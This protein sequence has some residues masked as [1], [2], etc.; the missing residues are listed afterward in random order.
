M[1]ELTFITGNQSKADYLARYLGYPIQHHKLDLDE[2][3]SLELREIVEHKVR[4]AYAVIQRPVIVEDV[5][6]EF[7]ALGRLP[8]TF[9]KFFVDEIPFETI[10]RMIDGMSRDATAKCVFGYFDGNSLEFFEGMLSGTIAEHPSGKNGF[11]WDKIFIPEG[12]S[13][14]RA[15]LDE[16]NDKKTY[17]QIKPIAKLKTFLEK[18]S[19]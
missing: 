5:S 10:C 16:E 4:Q 8:G 9:I 2:I 1:Q 19:S 18:Q 6:L 3:Q 17:L 11:G 12:Y 7:T 14:T 13:V 15:S